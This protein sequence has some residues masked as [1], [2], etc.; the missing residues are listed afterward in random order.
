MVDMTC[1]SD[2]HK[3]FDKFA[4]GKVQA[5]E[6]PNWMH[7][8][9]KVA[10]YVFQGPYSELS[11]KGFSARATPSRQHK[12]VQESMKSLQ[13]FTVRFSILLSSKCCTDTVSNS[14]CSPCKY[15]P[16]IRAC[17]TVYACS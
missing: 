8:S 12:T 9:G 6:L 14:T 5:G 7:V 16:G 10:W 3:Q 2:V 15:N 1:C 11:S 17:Q 4:N 13:S